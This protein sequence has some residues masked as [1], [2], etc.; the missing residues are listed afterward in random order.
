[1]CDH[2]VM[3][4]VKRR[5]V[6]RRD[7]FRTAAAGAAAAAVGATAGADPAEA[8]M[9]K[10]S[11]VADMT[12]ELHEDFP[13]FFGAQ[14]FWREQKFNWDQHKFNLLELR[15][16]EHTGTHVDAPLHFS[17]DGNSVAEVPVEDWV[18]PLVVIDIR[19]KVAENA[20]AQVTPEDIRG[21]IS[22][23]GAIPPGACVAMNSGWAAH[24][25]SPMFRNA[26][27]EGKMHFPGF[28]VEAAQMLI[29]ETGAVGLAV[30]SLSLDHGPSGDFATHYAWLPTGRWG[31]ECIANL[32]AAPEAG[33]T[34]VVGAPKHRGGTG[35]PAR[36]MLLS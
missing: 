10:F 24:V 2:C 5:M 34:L 14:Q 4:S 35:G 3:E 36:V 27:S 33:A 21:W 6:S 20:D 15:V 7:F 16:N 12:H 9:R 26:D 11:S 13:T 19:E 29:V 1:M 23:N 17:K 30:D 18:A 25:D 31:L 32:D 22:R 28:H 8:K